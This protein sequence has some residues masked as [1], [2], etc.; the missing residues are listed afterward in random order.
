MEIFR[1][2]GDPSASITPDSALY[3]DGIEYSTFGSEN[4]WA[5]GNWQDFT[6]LRAPVPEPATI[7]LLG[8]G[9][10]ALLRKRRPLSNTDWKNSS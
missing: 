4:H 2:E 8:L 9:S 3:N 1:L 7:F 10:L 5:G 6:T